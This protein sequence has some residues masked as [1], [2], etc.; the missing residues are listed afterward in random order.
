MS[1]NALPRDSKLRE[2]IEMA[3]PWQRPDSIVSAPHNTYD[4]VYD[5]SLLYEAHV[6]A[7]ALRK[8]VQIYPEHCWAYNTSYRMP[9]KDCAILTVA[10]Y[11]ALPTKDT[12][13]TLV[14]VDGAEVA[15]PPDDVADDKEE[16]FVPGYKPNTEIPEGIVQAVSY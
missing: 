9:R 16:V 14:L 8:H 15:G 6:R 2:F 12:Q 4:L 11:S 13:R 10:L 1:E 5:G 7:S 3:P